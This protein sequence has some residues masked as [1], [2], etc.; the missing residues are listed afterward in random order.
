M[1]RPE[2]QAVTPS[3]L[4]EH[5]LPE[6]GDD[7]HAR[8]HVLVVGG[9]AA[10]PGA[11]RLAGEAALRAGAG[12]LQIATVAS[13]AAGLAVAV[14]EA[15]VRALPELDGDIAPV[16][17]KEL[18]AVAGDCDAV[19]LGTGADDVEAAVTLL[20]RLVPGLGGPVVVDALGSAFLTR[21]SDGLRHLDGQVVLT[22]NPG[23]LARTAGRDED[24]VTSD[25][26]EVALRVAQE[27]GVVVLCG[28]TDKH[29]V[30]PQG[31]AW[32]VPGG[33]PG[34][35]VSG[36]GDV[37]AGIVCGLLARGASPWLAAVWGAHLHARAGE[38]LAG[39]VGA[40]GFL[41]RELPREVPGLLAELA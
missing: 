39:T 6:P 24:E 8:G 29:V 7:K 21:H 36:S 18:V 11:V 41:A 28:G 20:E 33:G 15:A 34:L 1:S 32:V 10:T 23:E 26:V 3:L 35:G 30:T 5:P 13:T 27:S 16:A 17:A 22:V 4:R 38:R 40:V 37:Q 19:L 25:P 2:P 14:P 12:K 31:E 9:A